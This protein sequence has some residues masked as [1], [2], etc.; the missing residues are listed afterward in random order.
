MCVFVSFSLLLRSA[1][2]LEN[3]LNWDVDIGAARV[4][5]QIHRLG[6]DKLFIKNHLYKSSL[7]TVEFHLIRLI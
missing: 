1:V 6:R 7:K 3:D 5:G 2:C 4:V